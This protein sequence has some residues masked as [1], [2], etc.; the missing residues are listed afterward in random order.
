MGACDSKRIYTVGGIHLTVTTD[1]MDEFVVLV[2][3]GNKTSSFTSALFDGIWTSDG[4]KL[5][6]G[7]KTAINRMRDAFGRDITR[8]MMD[9]AYNEIIELKRMK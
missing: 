6:R 2:V 7:E 8:S 9:D 4:S 5:T 1:D 3:K